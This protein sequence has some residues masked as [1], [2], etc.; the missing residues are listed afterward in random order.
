MRNTGERAS[1]LWWGAKTHTSASSIFIQLP[2]HAAAGLGRRRA[3]AAGGNQRSSCGSH[4]F[5]FLFLSLTLFHLAKMC[6]S[7]STADE[8]SRNKITISEQHKV[9]D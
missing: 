7:L 9:T 8:R 5:L 1:V 2:L 3:A 4:F 6:V